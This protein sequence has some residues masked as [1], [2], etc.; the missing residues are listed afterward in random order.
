MGFSSMEP[1]LTLSNIL[2]QVIQI[3]KSPQSGTYII[4][5]INV[6]KGVYFYTPAADGHKV[7]KKLTVK[8][9]SVFH[10]NHSF[11]Q[12]LASLYFS[13]ATFFVFLGS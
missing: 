12:C 3:Q 2:G 10:L 7:T 9:W 5:V 6:Q 4:D 1:T 11:I 8:K 13:C